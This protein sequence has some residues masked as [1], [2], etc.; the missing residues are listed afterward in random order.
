MSAFRDAACNGDF[1]KMQHLVSKGANVHEKDM[2]GKNACMMAV[3]HNRASVVNWMLT[4][5]GTRI[6]DKDAGGATTL[7][8]AGLGGR[9]SILQWLLEGGGTLIN[10]VVMY[11]GESKS[12]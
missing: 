10:D 9:H 8:H 12:V 4:S 2:F 11:H 3:I 7:A 1:S 6:S 5:G